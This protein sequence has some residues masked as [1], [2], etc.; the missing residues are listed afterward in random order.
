MKTK[1]YISLVCLIVTVQASIAQ[2][3]FA[4]VVNYTVS[5]PS[6]LKSADFNDD[7]KIDIAI[8][9]LNNNK[10]TTL[11][12]IGNG[13]FTSV[14][15]YAVNNPHSMCF[16][17][18]NADG[19]LDIVT[20]SSVD[21]DIYIRN[22]NAMGVFGSPNFIT[23]SINP[24]DVCSEDFNND[25]K[26]DLAIVADAPSS[27]VIAL[28]LGNNNGTFSNPTTFTVG[29]NPKKIITADF[30]GDGKAD[31]A[32]V[33]F[34]ASAKVSILL[35]N[36]AGSFAAAAN[37][38]SIGIAFNLTTGDFNNDNNPD[39][40]VVSAV[41][42][43]VTVLLGSANG[44]IT[45][46][47]SFTVFSN[48]ST[49]RSVV[50]ADFNGDGNTD[51]ATANSN[52]NN[53]SVFLGNGSGS[54]SASTNFTVGTSP[55]SIISADFNS[56]GKADLATSN[57]GSNNISIL[58]NTS[59]ITNI[60]SNNSIQNI[61]T[62]IF[63]NPSNDFVTINANQTIS[64]I[65]ITDA[66]GKEIELAE[67]TNLNSKVVELNLKHLCNGIY[68]VNVYTADSIQKQKILINK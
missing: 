66:L 32:T 11:N 13:S 38:N 18:F 33:N 54:F 56:D 35:S 12:G 30:N 68:F 29:T 25:S 58:I 14:N 64:K 19:N 37:Y 57:Q 28:Q 45:S 15:N 16:K 67:P 27:N 23:T 65:L 17:D 6:S 46:I 61:T 44:S 8:S 62:S 10:V 22:G 59:V 31:L 20:T 5:G 63:P 24:G 21:G 60:H 42:S 39:L 2:I 7:G 52:S 43:N 40:A 49:P 1:N 48:N 50:S 9:S 36:G 41:S 34:D 26:A 4:P 51:I 3:S 47:S 53:I 55:N